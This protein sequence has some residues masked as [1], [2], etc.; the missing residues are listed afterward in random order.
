MRTP[1]SVSLPCYQKEGNARRL[2]LGV[3]ILAW[4]SVSWSLSHEELMI[5]TI[6][7]KFEESCKPKCNEVTA[8]FDFLTSFWQGNKSIDEWHNI[9]QT[10][11]AL[12][13]Y[14]PETAKILL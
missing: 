1:L 3:V 10:Q 5:H 12:A 11:V 6:W 9:V 4:N 13:K 7:E 8:R 14:P 2:L